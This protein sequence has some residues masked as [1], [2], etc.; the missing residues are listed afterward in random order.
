MVFKVPR[1]AS[2][3]LKVCG[4]TYALLGFGDVIIPGIK[5]QNDLRVDII[6]YIEK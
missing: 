2:S 5:S 4:T 3:P 1:L 6:V